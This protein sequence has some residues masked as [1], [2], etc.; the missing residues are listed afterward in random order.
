ML[1]DRTN[2]VV[3]EEAAKIEPSVQVTNLDMSDSSI[4]KAQ[5]KEAQAN[6]KPKVQMGKKWNPKPQLQLKKRDEDD[7]D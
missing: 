1:G 4:K 3:F 7:P 6:L 2:L 5:F